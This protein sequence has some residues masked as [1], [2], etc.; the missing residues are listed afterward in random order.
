LLSLHRP[1]H[2][3]NWHGV[4]SVVEDGIITKKGERL[5]FEV[6]IF[7]TGFAT[8]VYPVPVRGKFETI[9]EYFKANGGPQA[10]LGTTV[11]GFPN[12][13]MLF[14]PNTGTG[15]TS[16]LY[17]T[18]I[19][20]DYIIQLIKPILERQVS[21]VEVKTD[22]TDR[23]NA[24]IHGL[25][26]KSLFTQC[27]SWYRVGGEGK[28]T[29]IFPGSATTFWW[30]LRKPNWDHFTGV[31]TDT[32]RDNLRR[33]RFASIIRYL[34]LASL[35]ALVCWKYAPREVSLVMQFISRNYV[36]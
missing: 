18:E 36:S 3:I 14:G 35:I 16:V 23:Y 21:S 2:N 20:V 24:K 4:D 25:L 19:Q 17:T 12:F 10:Y 29:N 32:W 6:L 9:Q 34:C 33:K 28:I 31:G 7:A 13:F 30:W 5:P 1:N 8:D 27:L 22:P 26:N 11:P 15:H